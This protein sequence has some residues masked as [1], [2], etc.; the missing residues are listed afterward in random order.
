MSAATNPHAKVEALMRQ[1]FG[2]PRDPRSVEYKAGVRAALEFR[3]LRQSLVCAY[4]QGT[5]G[6]DA[7]Y[8]GVDEGNAIWREYL[9]TQQGAA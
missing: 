6:S 5:A 9:A 8:S 7:F 2:R 4:K 1:A 3:L